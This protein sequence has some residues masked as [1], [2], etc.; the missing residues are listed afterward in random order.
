VAKGGVML[1]P[2]G[3]IGAW[4]LWTG[5]AASDADFLKKTR[6][7]RDLV[8]GEKAPFTNILDRGHQVVLAAWRQGKQFVLQP[9]FAKSD[10]KFTGKETLLSAAV[11]ADRAGNER[12]VPLHLQKVRNGKAR[13]S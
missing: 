2:C 13:L 1:Q 6:M 12:A 10:T 11:A 7:S 5:A 8:N 4:D 3:W 9:T